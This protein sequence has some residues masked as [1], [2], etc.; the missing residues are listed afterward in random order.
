MRCIEQGILTGIFEVSSTIR[1]VW[2]L[3]DY[4]SKKV[5]LLNSKYLPAVLEGTELDM[6]SARVGSL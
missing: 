4:I 1:Y 5:R 3:E 6:A 2:V